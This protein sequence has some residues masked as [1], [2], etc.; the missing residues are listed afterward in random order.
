[1]GPHLS[2]IMSPAT[3]SLLLGYHGNSFASAQEP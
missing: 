1:L 2:S 3:Q